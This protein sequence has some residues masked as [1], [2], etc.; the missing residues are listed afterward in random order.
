VSTEANLLTELVGRG[1]RVV[2]RWDP[3]RQLRDEGQASGHD[4]RRHEGELLVPEGE[5]VRRGLLAP[6]RAQEG[7]ALGED[8]RQLGQV[9]GGGPV[10]LRQDRVQEATPLGWGADQ[11]EHLLRP[12]ED[13]AHRVAD[14]GGAPRQAVDGHPLPHLGWSV[15]GRHHQLHPRGRVAPW[16]GQVEPHPGE[17]PRMPDQLCVSPGAVRATRDRDEDRLQ[18]VRLAGAVRAGH[19]RQPGLGVQLRAG[20]ASEVLQDESGQAHRA[21]LPTTRSGP[22]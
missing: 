4:A 18:Q 22:A 14:R 1:H 8:P 7:V 9:A 3:I 11:E 2:Q 12:E 19:N 21:A 10:A 17:R 13:H 5:V 20:V 6:D 15:L 16:I